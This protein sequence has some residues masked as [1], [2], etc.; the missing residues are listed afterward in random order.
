MLKCQRRVL[1]A[2]FL[3]EC[4]KEKEVKISER[5]DEFGSASCTAALSV[6]SWQLMLPVWGCLCSAQR[7]GGTDLMYKWMT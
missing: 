4:A 5:V 7:N 2:A 1:E 3:L 6:M